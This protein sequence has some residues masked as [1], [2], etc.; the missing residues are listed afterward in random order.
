MKK[1]IFLIAVCSLFLLS[2]LGFRFLQA[3]YSAVAG[4]TGKVISV[5]ISPKNTIVKAGKT[6][7]FVAVV[8]VKGKVDKSVDWS[9]EGGNVNGTIIATDK[10]HASYK[11]PD[12]VHE[13]GKV[14]IKATSTVDSSISGTATIT[15]KGGS[16]TTTTTSTTTT[17][18]TL[19]SSS[20]TTAT[21]T[22]TT[23]S[24]ATTTTL[25][26]VTPGSQ[27]SNTI[28]IQ[29]FSFSPLNIGVAPGTTVT[30]KNNDSAPHTVTSEAKAEN[31]VSGSVSGISFDTGS[32]TT[33]DKT[34]T[35]PANAVPGTVIPY[36]CKV[37]TSGM[38]TK[39][40]YVT[41]Q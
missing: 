27:V 33:P 40:G 26:Q 19:T 36:F 8:K 13:G 12:S 18:T 25:P 29:S 5:K 24:S 1:G 37:H 15:V 11:A 17:S 28:T 30:V 6:R 10:K 31:Y 32:F 2:D 4:K 39:T 9:V 38:T 41:V 20:S 7:S 21:S 16:T 14:T 3:D 23:T 22:T 34:I 35:I